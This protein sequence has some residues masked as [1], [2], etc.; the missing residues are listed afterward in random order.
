MVGEEREKLIT[1]KMIIS[2]QLKLT[3][4][5]YICVVCMFV[6]LLEYWA[7]SLATC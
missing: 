5:S 7:V 6:Y 4:T 1:N 3:S 2:V